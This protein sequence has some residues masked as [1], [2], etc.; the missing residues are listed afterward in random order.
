LNIADRAVSRDQYVRRNLGFLG[1]TFSSIDGPETALTSAPVYA[2][3]S[4]S[5]AR[6]ASVSASVSESAASVSEEVL[7]L[8]VAVAVAA[9]GGGVGRR[10]VTEGGIYRGVASYLPACSLI[11]AATAFLAS[12]SLRT[13]RCVRTDV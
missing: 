3:C 6:S 8:A 1:L 10:I 7:A 4:V 12:S 11:A 2:V 9:V 5:G 13:C